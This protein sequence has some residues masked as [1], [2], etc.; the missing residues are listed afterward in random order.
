MYLNIIYIYLLVWKE[1]YV[2]SA[3]QKKIYLNFII[4]DRENIICHHVRRVIIID[5]QNTL[6]I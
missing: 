4:I 5:Q 6:P 1:K 2:P 3:N